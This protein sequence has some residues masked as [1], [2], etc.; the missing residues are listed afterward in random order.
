MAD[1]SRALEDLI[2][3]RDL[4]RD[5]AL[6]L[7]AEILSG[8][9]PDARIAARASRCRSRIG[10]DAGAS[11]VMRSPMSAIA[12]MRASIRPVSERA[13]DFADG[14]AILSLYVFFLPP[15][16]PAVSLAYA[17]EYNQFFAIRQ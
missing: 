12:Y 11:T 4:P 9:V 5:A 16:H 13:S 17:Y 10:M 2:A 1:F 14:D 15:I 6:G 8:N 3:R 7:M